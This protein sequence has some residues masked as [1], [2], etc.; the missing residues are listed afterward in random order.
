[1]Q[2]YGHYYVPG[3]ETPVLTE[4]VAGWA[5]QLLLDAMAKSKLPFLCRER[6]I[7]SSVF[8]SRY[9]IQKKEFKESLLS[10]ENSL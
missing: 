6:N 7:D 8:F 1:M 5:P 9:T 3:K 4:C 2:V 10:E